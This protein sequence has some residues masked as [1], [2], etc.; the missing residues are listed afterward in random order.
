MLPLSPA[1]QVLSALGLCT[2]YFFLTEENVPR[3]SGPH[4]C[5]LLSPSGSISEPAWNKV[6]EKHGVGRGGMERVIEKMGR[7]GKE[8]VVKRV[9]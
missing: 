6:G 2:G 9:E 7:K 3:G 8:M 5:L 1:T 4:L